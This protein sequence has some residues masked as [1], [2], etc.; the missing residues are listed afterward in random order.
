M[1]RFKAPWMVSLAGSGLFL[2]A[3]MPALAADGTALY[4]TSCAKCHGSDGLAGTP[5]GKAMKVPSLV[6]PRWAADD[7]ADALIAAFHENAKHKPVASKVTD[8]DLR[9]IAVH[10]RTLASKK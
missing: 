9:A 7:S 6:D 2:L 8:D 5:V 1:R 10:I 3:S 4:E